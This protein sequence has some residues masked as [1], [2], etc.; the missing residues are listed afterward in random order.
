VYRAGPPQES[1]RSG[2]SFSP[3]G[4]L[5]DVPVCFR[6]A[7]ATDAVDWMCMVSP[8]RKLY[9][10]NSSLRQVFYYPGWS[11]GPA[12]RT[13]G[14]PASKDT[15]S[16][17]DEARC[18]SALAAR[19]KAGDAEPPYYCVDPPG[20]PRK[21]DWPWGSVE[22]T[23]GGMSF[24]GAV[25]APVPFSTQ[26]FWQVAAGTLTT[27]ASYAN[28]GSFDLRWHKDASPS[29][30]RTYSCSDEVTF[31]F[32]TIA[33]LRDGDVVYHGTNG[34]TKCPQAPTCEVTMTGLAGPEA[35]RAA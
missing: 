10:Y 30:G 16:P 21:D 7:P 26:W 5:I 1:A 9:L 34:S 14:Q 31:M 11:F 18:Q 2:G 33:A 4:V 19:A 28:K 8:T 12:S 27:D 22:L 15:L 6:Y 35:G 23:V 29:A 17:Q 32:P 20:S 3:G 24:Q 25:R 13:H